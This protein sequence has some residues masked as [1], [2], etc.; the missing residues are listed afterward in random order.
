[1]HNINYF[2][3][4]KE[5]RYIFLTT[6][7]SIIGVATVIFVYNHT[8]IYGATF[9]ALILFLAGRLL[10]LG[11]NPGNHPPFDKHPQL[12]KENAV[13]S[14]VNQGNGFK[15]G[16]QNKD[17]V[18]K[19]QNGNNTNKL[20]QNHNDTNKFNQ[21]KSTNK[22]THSNPQGG[23]GGENPSNS[24]NSA[25]NNNSNNTSTNSNPGAADKNT[26]NPRNDLSN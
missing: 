10:V 9:F 1:M 4:F 5:L 19:N 8:G 11:A 18:N 26:N 16:G 17:L 12:H 2:G 6:I 13:H 20:T 7:I 15:E 22:P 3:L 24:S 23:T 14:N 21:N 25:S